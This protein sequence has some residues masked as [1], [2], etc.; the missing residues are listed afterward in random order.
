M[1]EYV[2]LFLY[3]RAVELKRNKSGGFFNSLANYE[4]KIRHV[5]DILQHSR[6]LPLKL[7]CRF[8]VCVCGIHYLLSPK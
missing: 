6:Y 8:C 2:A 3:D 1:Y 4:I 7:F 5:Y